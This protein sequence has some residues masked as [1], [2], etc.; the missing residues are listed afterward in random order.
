VTLKLWIIFTLLK[1]CK[2]KRQ[3]EGGREEGREIGR[4][5]G[6]KERKMVRTNKMMKMKEIGEYYRKY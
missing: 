3:R 6:R 4:K 1:D 5:E 2:R